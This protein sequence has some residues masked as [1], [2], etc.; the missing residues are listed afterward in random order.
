M[1]SSPKFSVIIPTYNRAHM[2]HRA[3]N[4]VMSQTIDD[5]EIIVV[6]DCSDDNTDS[7]VR[8]YPKNLVRYVKTPWHG[9][10]TRARNLG[11][12]KAR[13]E[14]ICWL[15]SDDMYVPYYLEVL[16]EAI[17]RAPE[18]RIFNFGG[19]NVH[20]G[21]DTTLRMV[22]EFQKGQVF[23]AGNIASGHFIFKRE[24]IDEVGYIPEENDC[25]QFAA[26]FKEKFPE[27]APL[28]PYP[29]S[30]LGNP[31]G[32]DYAY[33]YMLTRENQPTP[34]NLNLYIIWGRGDKEL[35]L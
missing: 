21:Y 20:K 18:A 15:D 30:E 2:V 13:G 11:M 6:D 33:F 28:Y 1:K 3:L 7:V 16:S 17:L 29:T 35:A 8:S 26:T 31:W 25:W 12:K 19:I 10:R 4:S 27:V 14:W 9:D 23:R 5:F 24:L 34:L 22:T 32:D